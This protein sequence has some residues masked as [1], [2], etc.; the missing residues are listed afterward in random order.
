MDQ[1]HDNTGLS[2]PQPSP[3]GG[4]SVSQPVP[5]QPPAPVQSLAPQQVSPPTAP[6]QPPAFVPPVQPAPMHAPNSAQQSQS[7]AQQP[8]LD[9]EALD[10]EWVQKARAIVEQTHNDPYAESSA[11]SQVR[12]DYLKRRYGKE[13]KSS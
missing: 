8:D 12:T 2:L 11:L 6:M 5:A 13:L 9:D 10:A 1:Q 7:S 4:F 3:Q